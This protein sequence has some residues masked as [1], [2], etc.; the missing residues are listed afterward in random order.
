MVRRAAGVAALFLVFA[1]PAQ[2]GSLG[3]AEVRGTDGA[4]IGKATGG[5]Y[6]YPADGSV[7]RIGWSR[8][9]AAK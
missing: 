3:L 6:A 9:T 7:L 2:A 5:S 8:A 4:L 1:A